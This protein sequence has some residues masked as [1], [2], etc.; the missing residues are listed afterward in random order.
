MFFF[1]K[2]KTIVVDC[3][4]TSPSAAGVAPIEK[5]AKF[6]PD[7]F[8]NLPST[9]EAENKYGLKIPFS[10]IKSC[11]GFL[12]LYKQ[13]FIIPLWSDFIIETNND[14]WR[15]QFA[16][17]KYNVES[18]HSNQ[19]SSDFYE[20]HHV[21]LISPWTFR[22]KTGVNF[23]FMNPMWNQVNNWKDYYIVPGNINFKYQNSSNVNMFFPKVESKL[24]L[25]VNTPLIHVIPLSDHKIDIKI[26]IISEADHEKTFAKYQDPCTFLKKYYYNKNIID[27]TE[28]KCPFG[29][30]K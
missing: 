20:Y 22:E 6:I 12:D 19:L 25:K 5:T 14:A 18:H 27:E 23:I 10:T 21:K 17:I 24:H 11:P 30:G 1:F 3:F 13:G 2:R 28:K 16:N 4:T 8:K 7:W 29:F 26:H 9:I 15:L